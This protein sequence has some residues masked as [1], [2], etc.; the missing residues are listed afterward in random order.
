MKKIY[1][2]LFTLLLASG[3]AAQ[4]P[5]AYFMEGSTLRSQF[6]PAFA[7]LRGYVNIPG[8]GG[9][10]INVSGNLSI[11]K[12]L[13]PRNG[14]LV[15]L[16]DSSV[17]TA[18]ALSGLKADNL[19]G[20]DT[21]VNLIGFGAFTRNHKNFW[22]FDLN[23]RTTAD[24]TLPYSLFAF[25][26]EGTGSDIHNIGLTADSYLEAAFSYSFPLLDDRLYIGVRGKFLVGAA[27]ARMYFTRFN[28]THGEE[29]WRIDAAGGL[30]ITPPVSTS[31]PSATTP[32]RRFTSWTTST[33]NP[34]ARRYGFAVD[35][36]ATYD[37]LP[38]L[39]ASL[40]VNDL[41]FI[42]W[43]KNKN[44]TGYSAK[45]LS[46]TGV[47]VTEDGT[48]SPDFDIDVLEFHKGAAKSVSRM[49]RASINAGL[50]YE[51]WRHKIGIGLLYTARVWE[52]KTLHNITGSVN[53]HPIRWFTVTGSYSVID[54][55]GGAVGL[56][57]NLNP[58]WINFY[59][60][61]DIVT[62]KHTP[63]FIPIKQS[64]MN[65]TLG[66]GVPIGRRSHRIAAYVYGKDRR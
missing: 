56:A 8:L 54:H 12:I 14:K 21:R 57:L 22:S 64:V 31:R 10:D 17:S 51:V 53:F 44:V 7:P 47:T 4:N 59:L 2:F 30:D 61:T 34:L 50:E 29:E 39:Q 49:L 15:T 20:L 3:A 52:Y 19:L 43:S 66:I 35:F 45:E 41:G 25:L 55:R 1:A 26:K 32:A 33:S 63:Q 46:F 5:T 13:Y 24:A 40:A 58:S 6:N 38:N 18:D 27:R 42:G 48:E 62:A 65:V 9:L 23:A 36:G 16:L 11:D 60:A 37:I 28:V